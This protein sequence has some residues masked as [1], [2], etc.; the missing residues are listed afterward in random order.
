VH[1]GGGVDTAYGSLVTPIY[2]TT[3]YEIPSIAELIEINV[4]GKMGYQYSSGMNPTQ[5]AA[6]KKIAA[7]EGGEEALVF[8][9]G[10]AAITSTISTYVKKGDEI[11]A[12]NDLY[13]ASHRFLN[14]LNDKYGIKTRFFNTL[15]VGSAEKL[16]NDKT[17]LMYIETPTNPAMRLLDIAQA[18]E[19]AKKHQMVSV[20]DNTFASP[21]NQRPLDLGVDIV[22][23]SSTKSLSGHHHVISGVAVSTSERI[24]EIKRNRAL[25]GQSLDPFG[26]FLLITGMQT[27]ALRVE[28]AR[29]NAL[30][31]AKVLEDHP[32]VQKV[33]YPGL[34]SHPQ[35][36]LAKRQMIGFGSML[37]F[38]VKDGV[39]GVTKLVDSLEVAKLATSLG[40][41]DTTVTVPYIV[42]TKSLSLERQ[43][44]IGITPGLIRVSVGIE[45]FKDLEHDFTQALGHV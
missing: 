3:T 33:H 12:Q 5:R 21:L 24:Q 25:Y 41:V 43:E 4:N 9:G 16:V 11:L 27:L 28:R 32:K 19:I 35:H 18:V 38:E 31:L 2:Q 39:E 1:I 17:K 26:A 23:E 10:M 15:D 30:A 20:I 8:S 45:D 34:E 22:V 42:Y 14:T 40:G 29:S 13:S 37:S 6:A 7:L 36:G 44:E